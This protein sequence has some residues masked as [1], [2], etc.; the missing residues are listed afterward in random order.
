MTA[1]IGS[2]Y[3]VA[4]ELG[5]KDGKILLKSPA[6]VQP[7]P[8]GRGYD[9][10]PVKFVDE[11]HLYTHALLLDDRA[12]QGLLPAYEKYQQKRAEQQQYN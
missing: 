11:P 3:I 7:S 4:E 2:I 5:R 8:D 1:P 10:Q 9:L 6:F 12:P